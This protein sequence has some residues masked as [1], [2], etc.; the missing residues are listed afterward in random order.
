MRK[1]IFLI[2]FSHFLSAQYSISTAERSALI[3]IYQS[4]NGTSWS[5][6]WDLTKDPQNWYGIK[7]KNHA[8][9]AINLRGNALSGNFPSNLAVFT[10]LVSLDLSNN[11]LKGEV[12][13]SLGIL[14]NLISLSIDDNYLTGDP[15]SAI[16]PLSSLAELSIGHN[17]FVISDI[18][19]LLQNF[20]LL[21]VLDISNSNLSAVPQKIS[22][23][24]A[25]E[26]LNL[27][28]N[29][30]KNGFE[31][32]STLGNLKELNLAGNQLS[33]LPIQLG[34][35]I[36][37]TTLD[38][39]RNLLATNLETSLNNLKNLEWL[40]LENN[41]LQ[42]LPSNIS[43]IQKLAHLNL[44]RNLLSGNFSALLNL[45]NL[46]QLYL[47][48][49][50]LK[51]G[52]PLIILQLPKLQML[53]LSGNKLSGAIP[54]KIPAITFIDNNRFTLSAI[55]TFLDSNP[56]YTDFT[57]SPQRYDDKLSVSAALGENI[58]LKQSL[59]GQD[60]QFSWF[61]NLEDKQS[62]TAE[63]YYINQMKADDFTDYTCEAYFAKSYPNYFLEISF[64]REPVTIDAVLAT[65]E[66][67]NNISV[68]P[69][70][71]SDILFVQAVNEKVENISI[72]DMSGK[73]ILTDSGPSKLR[74]NVHS[75]PSG[76]YIILIKTS[77]GNKTL[78]FIKK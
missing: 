77:T 64:F 13:Q 44:G 20:P 16:A 19:S 66:F 24:K 52:F 67:A 15:T 2:F 8:V 35:L 71:T 25:L 29:Q 27:S 65:K 32:F 56:Q 30:L 7:I 49:N 76:A 46:Q 17:L 36:Q 23:L 74:I 1:F 33:T 59:S 9:S 55:K 21:N 61:K 70:P 58:S 40:S 63:N 42:N 48:H 45:K 54:M 12:S 78:K 43:T 60:Y 28:D 11:N 51:D 4:T 72:Y 73:I 62:V 75:F 26:N 69:N 14:S 57:F 10:D 3:S 5:Q 31:N 18:N 41:L 22:T 37:L 39:S 47:D 38:L 68:Y 34:N 6:T 50:L 53:S